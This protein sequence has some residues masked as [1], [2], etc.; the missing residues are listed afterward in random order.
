M[1]RRYAPSIKNRPIVLTLSATAALY[2]IP[3][4]FKGRVCRF[5]ADAASCDVLFGDE[6]VVAALGEPSDVTDTVIT[7]EVTSGGHIGTSEAVYWEIP[8]DQDIT[9]FSVDGSGA[10]KLYIEL[11]DS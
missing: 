10:G 9:H 3:A 4:R 7:E 1:S 5:V 2:T 8:K 11:Y 6:N